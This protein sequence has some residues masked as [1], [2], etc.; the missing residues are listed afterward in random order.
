MLLR[1][2]HINYYEDGVGGFMR[3]NFDVIIIILIFICI[4]LLICCAILLYMVF[5]YKNELN[6]NKR[7]AII[8]NS[9][10][11][12]IGNSNDRMDVINIPNIPSRGNL[13][14]NN[15]LKL[16]PLTSI[17]PTTTITV[18]SMTSSTQV[19]PISPATPINVLENDS[20]NDITM[21]NSCNSKNYNKKFVS[22]NSED[23][24]LS[25]YAS[26]SKQT[27]DTSSNINDYLSHSYS[28]NN[29]KIRKHQY[30]HRKNNSSFINSNHKRFP[31]IK[32]PKPLYERQSSITSTI[33]S[34]KS[35][36]KRHYSIRSKNHS[37][38]HSSSNSKV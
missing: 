1:M 14:I 4:L 7:G 21:Y 27:F 26:T 10:N 29:G 5:L 16:S 33:G 32:K 22:I 19:T 8:Y 37:R 9:D 28:Y 6:Q 38:H 30:H 25:S 34:V 3:K 11:T 20:I 24:I 31:S 2:S 17:V 12:N 15:N 18:A 23:N 35:M 13:D 36:I